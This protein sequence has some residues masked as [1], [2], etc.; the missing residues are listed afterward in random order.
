M[1]VGLTLLT[2][3]CSVSVSAQ[4]NPKKDAKH[5]AALAE[6]QATLVKIDA[7][8]VEFHN[9]RPETSKALWSHA[10]DVTLTGGAGGPM[11]KGWTNVSA[12]LDWASAQ[13]TRGTQKN[14]RFS[15]TV[16]GDLALVL[17]YEHIRFYSPGVTTESERNYRVTMAL[18]REKDGWRVIHRHADTMTT[19]QT[20]K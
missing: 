5:E 12:R 11:E 9:G 14:T 7:A 4:K 3:C 13:Y 8:H 18:R 16:S 1:F 15:V 20:P 10:D 6:V 19:K 17:Q 2:V